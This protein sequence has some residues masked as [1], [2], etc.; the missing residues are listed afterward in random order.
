MT[1]TLTFSNPMAPRK[2]GDGR[3]LS[4][5]SFDLLNEGLRQSPIVM[6]DDFRVSG[7]PFGPHPHAGFSAVTYVLDDSPGRLRSRDSLGN[8]H[9]VGR[10]G[11]V[12]T[13]AADGVM[14]EEMLAEPAPELHGLQFFVN[15]TGENKAI[16]PEVFALDADALPV[17]TGPGGDRVHVVVGDYD[18]IAS[19]LRP[20]EPFRL[21][22]IELA[23][24]VELAQAENWFG[25]IYARY[26]ALEI[27]YAGGRIRLPVGMA[28]TVEGVGAF[29]LETGGVARPLFLAGPVVK[30]RVLQQGPFIMRETSEIDAAIQRYQRGEMGRLTPYHD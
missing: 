15:L 4:V 3:A 26:D 24:G 16:P 9:V 30:E 20:V 10:G 6:F 17:W 5:Q 18:G 1:R 14:H 8:N 2:R 12:W 27:Q 25:L 22:D 11:I 23:G 21:L 29:R 13:Q 19:P 28:I 7:H